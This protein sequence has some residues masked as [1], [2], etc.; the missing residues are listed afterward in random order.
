MTITLNGQ[1]VSPVLK[2]GNEGYTLK[3][4]GNGDYALEVDRKNAGSVGIFGE[5]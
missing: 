3:D 2:Q 4:L 1:M 5:K